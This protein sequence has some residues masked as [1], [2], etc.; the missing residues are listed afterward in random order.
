MVVCGKKNK[1][2]NEVDEALGDVGDQWDHVGFD[3]GSRLVVELVP[4]KRTAANTLELT[5]KF[6]A[7]TGGEPPALIC[8]D[9]YVCYQAALAA[10]YGLPA[11]QA[12]GA[13]TPPVHPRLVYATVC[14]K[15]EN[16]HVV[17]VRRTLVFGTPEQ[18]KAALDASAWST[19]INTSF[20][21]RYNGTERHFNSR[22]VRK[23]CGF[24][25][26]LAVHVAATWIGVT[27]YN[28]CRHHGGLTIKQE[29]GPLIQRTPAM[30]AG[31]Q[32]RRLTLTDIA[33]TP[34]PSAPRGMSRSIL[35]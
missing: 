35:G 19:N 16:G 21:E 18:L 11:G 28:F 7:R 26:D 29:E 14:K 32:K 20:V 9:E 27:V 34:I 10:V 5:K 17:E 24:S 8:T 3:V 33:H 23:T 13:G 30:A 6:A 1:N 2:I 15:R 25:K 22:N 4:G 31:L 12:L